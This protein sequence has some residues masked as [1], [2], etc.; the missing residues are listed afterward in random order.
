MASVVSPSEDS[1]LRLADQLQVLSQVAE[2]LTYRLL[3]LEERLGGHEDRIGARLEEVADLEATHG[4]AMDERLG[5]TEERLAR[6]E[7]ALRGLD[8]AGT[9]RHLQAVQPPALQQEPPASLPVA[10]SFDLGQEEIDPFLD[11]GEQPFMDELIAG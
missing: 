10:E 9:S 3:E 5:D 2:A 1:S 11:E 7:A 8:R 4:A 6:I